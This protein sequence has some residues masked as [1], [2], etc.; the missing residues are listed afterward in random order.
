MGKQLKRRNREKSAPKE[1]S[2]TLLKK[3][4]PNT[5]IFEEITTPENLYLDIFIPSIPLIVE[6]HGK[7]HYEFTPFFHGTYAKFL[8]SKKR[9]REKI[10]W[11]NINN[12]PI[13]TLPYDKENEWESIILKALQD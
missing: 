2:L 1:K 13:A 3:L 7:Q 9:D 6:V 12:F 11:A 4:F 8:L 5:I 10:E